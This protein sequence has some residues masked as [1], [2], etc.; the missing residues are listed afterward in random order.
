MSAPQFP[1]PHRRFN[2]LT[3]RWVLV[4]AHRTARPWL[5]RTEQVPT[6]PRPERDPGCY[7]CPGSTRAGGEVNPEYRETFV[8]TNDFPALLPQP[9]PKVDEA[10][11]LFRAEREAGTCR[12]ICFSPRH[13][14][15]LAEMD[16]DSIVRVVDLWAAQT[17]ELG[18]EYQWVQVFENKGEA[19]GASNPHPHGQIWAGTALPSLI[20]A[21]DEQQRGYFA[22][23]RRQLLLDYAA[24]ESSDAERTVVE[25]DE[26]LIVVP[27]WAVWPFEA[28]IVPKRPTTRIPDLDREQRRA[29]AG[30]L[31]S[32][33]IRYDN[34]FATSF[35]YS[36]GWHGAPF[37]TGPHDHW[38]LHG[39][40]YPPLLR[41]ATIRK[42]MVG[43]ELL[44]EEQRDLTPEGAARRL[45]EVPATHYLR[46][47]G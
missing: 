44:S 29:L 39:H 42:F 11:P 37:D 41:S 1:T 17:E 2:P 13:D 16:E 25:N 33:L 34:L 7:L 38:Q 18:S 46:R 30:A 28:L 36:L 12:V 3:G 20:A 15:T 27:Y 32:L 35:P 8:F 40:A 21:E 23:L 4:S 9:E 10:S 22:D 24:A 19:M 6:E 45:R 26:W 43:Y 5:G 14:L 47:D 31:S